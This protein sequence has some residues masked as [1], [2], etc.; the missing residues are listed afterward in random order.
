MGVEFKIKVDEDLDEH[1]LHRWIKGKDA[2]WALFDIYSLMNLIIEEDYDHHK[3]YDKKTIELL[4]KD[5]DE[6]IE[7]YNLWSCIKG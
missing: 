7:H 1:E 4:K 5:I 3:K 2:T 6:F